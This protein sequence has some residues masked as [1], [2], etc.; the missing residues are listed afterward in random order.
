MTARNF[1]ID[2]NYAHQILGYGELSPRQ[3]GR[4]VRACQSLWSRDNA[5]DEVDRAKEDSKHKWRPE[6]VMLIRDTEMLAAA[7]GVVP[8]DGQLF[9]DAPGDDGQEIPE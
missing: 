5:L 6:T 9:G 3:S 4:L 1:Q 7:H 8:G 2:P